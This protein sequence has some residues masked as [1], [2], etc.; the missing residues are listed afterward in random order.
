MTRPRGDRTTQAHQAERQARVT[1]VLKENPSVT[2]QQLADEVGASLA[3]VKRDLS[4]LSEG[5]VATTREQFASYVQQQVQLL[6]KA[7]EEV[8]EGRLPP[9]A[10]NSIRGMMDSIARLTV[11]GIASSCSST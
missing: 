11:V 2:Q 5:F 7:V 9:E 1:D 6:T 8:W 10:A 3:T 4:K